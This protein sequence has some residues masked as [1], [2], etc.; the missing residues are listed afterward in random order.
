M[1]PSPPLPTSTPRR[2]LPPDHPIR[3]MQRPSFRIALLLSTPFVLLAL[4]LWGT[5]GWLLTRPPRVVASIAFVAAWVLYVCI[6]HIPV[7][8]LDWPLVLSLGVIVGALLP[9]D[10]KTWV[11]HTVPVAVL[12]V[13][14]VVRVSVTS[15]AAGIEKHIVD[16]LAVLCCVVPAWIAVSNLRLWVPADAKELELLEKKVYDQYIVSEFSLLKVAG[17]GTV[18]VPYCGDGARLPPRNLVLVH[19]Y[20]AGNGFW[21]AVSFRY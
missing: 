13:Y 11:A 4:A 20:M 19:G 7:R 10:K 17:L 18:H 1:A 12:F 2:E 9:G 5:I 6:P 15:T 21:S 8:L 16:A 14:S 3:R